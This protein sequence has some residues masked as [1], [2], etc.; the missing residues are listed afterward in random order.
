M[1][2]ATFKWRS[3]ICFGAVIGDKV[4][5]LRALADA[6]Q[7]MLPA[8]LI[9]FIHVGE[10]GLRDLEQLLASPQSSWPDEVL[11]A[12]TEVQL[13]APLPR[14][15]NGVYGV[16]LNYMK[17][18]EEVARTI[19]SGTVQPDAPVY[20]NKPPNTVI[21]HHGEIICNSNLTQQLDWEV[22]LAVIIGRTGRFIDAADWRSYVFG[23]TCIN[24]ISARDCS[25]SGHWFLSKGQDSFA[26]CGPWIV[27]AAYIPD[28]HNLALRSY[29]NG[30]LMQASC[31]DDMLFKI[32][33]LLAD[34]S[35]GVTLEPGDIIAT[36]T[37]EG[38]GISRT[39]PIFLHPG[40]VVEVEIEKIGRL[41]NRVISSEQC[42]Q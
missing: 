10:V 41:T 14:P 39:P 34:L 31:T 17:H 13:L 4:V 20:F 8:T 25:R 28:P 3:R 30:E 32:P 22:E 24:D 36:G 26:P 18:I 37:P 11:I 15:A 12:L 6:H 5:D 19:D 33:A 40:D 2:L 1:R 21:G 27:P 9:D 35:Q 23:Y 7:I 38:V 16:G 42:T 29:V